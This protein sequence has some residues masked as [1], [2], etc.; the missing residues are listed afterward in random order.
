[1]TN[2]ENILK[3]FDVSPNELIKGYKA[4]GKKIIGCGPVYTPAEI[5]YAAGMAPMG[6]WGSQGEISAAKQYF[7]AF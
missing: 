5:V 4:E 3:K 6:L 1:M 7:A 2:I